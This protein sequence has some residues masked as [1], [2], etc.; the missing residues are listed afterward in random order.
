MN[1]CVHELVELSERDA[2]VPLKGLIDI[3]LFTD[4]EDQREHI[5]AADP[6]VS[7]TFC[8]SHLAGDV[9]GLPHLIQHE[10]WSA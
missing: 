4:L 6:V 9:V 3:L 8:T 2:P 10:V 5:E 1:T 7:R